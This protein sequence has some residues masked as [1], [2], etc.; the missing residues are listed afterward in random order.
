MTP[1]LALLPTAVLVLSLLAPPATAH[2]A[3]PEILAF[4]AGKAVDVVCFVLV[5]HV[6]HG[7]AL[8][9][10]QCVPRGGAISPAPL[11]PGHC[12]ERLVP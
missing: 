11:E 4:L 8:P 7:D 2:A 5:D 10:D 9:P 1:R 6:E 12:A 3:C